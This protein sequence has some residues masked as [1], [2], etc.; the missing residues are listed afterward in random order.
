MP[1]IAILATKMDHLQEQVQKL[2]QV[3]TRMAVQEEKIN[4][5]TKKVEEV[6]AEH[7]KCRSECQIHKVTTNIEWIKWFVMGNS[8]TVFGMVIGLVAHYIKG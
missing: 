6:R 3:I 2:A 5:L 7:E 8:A 1:D 4:S